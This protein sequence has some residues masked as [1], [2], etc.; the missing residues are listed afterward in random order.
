[1]DKLPN[2]IPAALIHMINIL[3]N[4]SDRQLLWKLSLNSEKVSLFVKCEIRAK[5]ADGEKPFY[6]KLKPRN[7]KKKSP[8]TLRR[9]KARKQRFLEK[10]GSRKSCLI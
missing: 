1:M 6:V 5:T 2:V 4:D 8:S 9:Q 7:R 3:D 10:E